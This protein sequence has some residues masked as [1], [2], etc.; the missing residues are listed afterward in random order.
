MHKPIKLMTDTEIG[1]YTLPD[2]LQVCHRLNCNADSVRELTRKAVASLAAAL[3]KSDEEFD[4]HVPK[5]L[6]HLAL[7]DHL[8]DRRTIGSICDYLNF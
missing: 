7:L 4:H 8:T 6:M 1:Q 3:D 5:A 2:D